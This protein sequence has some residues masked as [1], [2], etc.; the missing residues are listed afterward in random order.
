MIFDNIIDVIKEKTNKSPELLSREIIVL[1]GKD[2]YLLLISC[3]LSLQCR[4]VVTIPVAKRLF[5]IAKTPQEILSLSLAD[6]ERII[7]SINYYKTKAVRIRAVTQE[8]LQRFDG[9]VP[10]TSQALLSLKGVGIKTA[11]L[12]LAEAYDVAVICVDTHVHWLSNHWGLVNTKTPEETEQAL[13][14][15]VPQKYWREWNYWLVKWG[16]TIGCRSR[17]CR[18]NRSSPTC[19]EDLLD[20]CLILGSLLKGL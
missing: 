18:T 9:K 19:G 14:K 11:N 1:Y 7:K 5:S 3:L 8:L 15:V 12:V 17:G 6:L 10:K 13:Y 4:D 2:P 16:Q 20:R